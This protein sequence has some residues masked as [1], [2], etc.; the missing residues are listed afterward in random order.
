MDMIEAL[1]GIVG[2]KKSYLDYGYFGVLGADF[3][4]DGK[5]TGEYTP[6]PSYFAL[7]NLAA[8]LAP[9]VTVA[10]IPAYAVGDSPATYYNTNYNPNI[11]QV[12]LHKT[13]GARAFAYWKAGDLMT[14]TSE[15]RLTLQTAKL[16][17]PVRLLNLLTGDVFD[18][19][20]T[21]IE[22]SQRTDA[23]LIKNL[24]LT[25]TPFLLTFGDFLTFTPAQ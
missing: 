7:Q 8:A 13:N 3:D 22:K 24:P 18:V 17:R 16:P 19:P 1:N 6:K 5:S 9:D 20:D 2:D 14:E 4:A 10:P 11:F 25:D 21:H 23:F 12:G 15:D